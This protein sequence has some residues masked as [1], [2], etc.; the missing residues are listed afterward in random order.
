MKRMTITERNIISG[1]VSGL[2]HYSG[3]PVLTLNAINN[4]AMYGRFSEDFRMT[5][6]YLYW[7]AV[8]DEASSTYKIPEGYRAV[9]SLMKESDAE[10]GGVPRVAIIKS[11]VES[12]G[13]DRCIKKCD[14][15]W[16]LYFDEDLIKSYVSLIFGFEEA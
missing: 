4:M 12:A 3:C 6:K 15:S 2:R 10:I 7:K 1:I 5:I 13:F 8:L 14:E 9:V 11:G 16:K